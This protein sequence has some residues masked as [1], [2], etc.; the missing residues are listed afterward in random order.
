MRE[1]LGLGLLGRPQLRREVSRTRRPQVRVDRLENLE[2][3]DSNK[4]GEEI[5]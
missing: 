2:C 1:S 4:N 5:Q 3:V